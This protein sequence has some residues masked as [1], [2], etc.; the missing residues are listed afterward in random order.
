MDVLKLSLVVLLFSSC[1][2]L[3]YLT[4]QGVGQLKL[5]RSSQ[6]NIVILEDP[7]ISQ[8][9]KE[10]IKL[11]EKY[12]KFFYD[13]WQLP[14]TDI[15][16]ETAMLDRD[17]VTYLVIASKPNEIEAMKECFPLVGCFPYLGF[18]KKK[19]AFKYK[20]D[21][22]SRNY[23]TYMRK[24]LAYSTLGKFDDPILSTFFLYNEFELAETIFHELFHTIFFVKDEVDLNENLANFFGKAMVYEYFGRDD[25]EAKKYYDNLERRKVLFSRIKFHAN[26]LKKILKQD[27]WQQRKESYI[28]TNFVQDIEDVCKSSDIESCWP[29]KLK[30][31][32]ATFA[33]FMTYEKGQ[34]KIQSFMKK[35]DG[36]LRK[37]FA[38]LQK[39]YED[40]KKQ[41]RIKSFEKYILGVIK[42]S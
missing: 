37:L 4:E 32:S 3:T 36:D 28:S 30:W 21:L 13:Y 41:S 18:F 33:A 7:K 39:S 35:F 1:A 14:A 9:D 23:D 6:K 27:N 12:K 19:S 34:D 38:Y 11:I 25:K 8:K 29:L 10:K 16:N 5:L 31:N 20:K 22:E 40:Y 24:V 15:Y 26:E 17:A 42:N 2:R